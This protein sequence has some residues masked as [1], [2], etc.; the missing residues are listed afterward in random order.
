MFVSL[1][2][3][4]I[5]YR[6]K[7]HRIRVV[8][9]LHIKGT[10]IHS[11]VLI[12][13]TFYAKTFIWQNSTSFD[14]LFVKMVIIHT[15]LN[16]WGLLPIYRSDLFF[17]FFN[18]MWRTRFFEKYKEGWLKFKFLVL[19]IQE[20][21]EE[22]RGRNQ[23]NYWSVTSGRLYDSVSVLP[24]SQFLRLILCDTEFNTHSFSCKY[25]LF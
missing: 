11:K 18:V 21:M 23:N 24:T 9:S 15:V 16:Q 6:A 12:G 3:F 17:F 19:V 2:P 5:L 1:K 20:I 25:F 22:I 14:Q 10:N 4:K 8:G 7:I 13:W